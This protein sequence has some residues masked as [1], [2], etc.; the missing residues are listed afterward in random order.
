MIYTHNDAGAASY[1]FRLSRYTGEIMD[2]ADID[3]GKNH[4]WEDLAEDSNYVYIGDFGNNRGRRDNL[5]ILRVSRNALL[6]DKE[7]EA[8][9]IRFTYSD[10][11]SLKPRDKHDFDC[12]AF[13]AFGDSLYLFTKNRA[14]LTTNVYR[15]PKE[16]GKHVAEKVGS[17]DTQ[18][19]I[20]GADIR[21][22]GGNALLLVG[23]RNV[24]VRYAAFL[25]LFTGF[26][27][28]D[29]FVGTQQRLELAPHLQAEG[30]LWESDS[31]ALISSEARPGGA[32]V[33]YRVNL[34][35]YLSAPASLD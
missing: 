10:Q 20:T 33:L 32:A 4:D 25:W 18:G 13:I 6:L 12:E 26:E 1:L 34:E 24:G 17:Y 22:E 8:E 21:T 9:K 5:R 3:N 28:S 19:M 29:F 16:P 14:S 35:A 31:T 30:V 7:P 2:V 23:Y 11:E 27:G 15:I